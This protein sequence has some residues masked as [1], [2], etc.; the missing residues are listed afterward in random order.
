MMRSSTMC[1]PADRLSREEWGNVVTHGCMVLVFLVWMLFGV[2]DAWQKQPLYGFG[3]LV[4]FLCMIA[5]FSAS[6]LYHAMTP[7]TRAKEIFHVL[8]H[9]CIYLAIAGSYTPAVLCV[10]EGAARIGL[11]AF[12]WGMVL[13]G[14]FYKCFAR[15]KNSKLSLILYL[16]MGW[17]VVVLLPQL[18]QRV[19]L[20]F[21]LLVAGGGVAYSIGAVIY[22]K[23]PFA[24]AHVVW[25]LFVALASILQGIGFV[26]VLL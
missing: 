26:Y 7:G 13:I 1:M 16:C 6:T 25:H 9:I 15:K 22:A 14:I 18:F 19:S 8:D 10:M 12:Q 20:Q 23:N 5:M 21:L 3:I 24:Y 11:L 2:P 4:F 17:S